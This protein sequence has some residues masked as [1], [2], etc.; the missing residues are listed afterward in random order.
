MVMSFNPRAREGR[1]LH[2]QVL[3]VALA[4]VSTHAP[5]RGATRLVSRSRRLQSRAVSTHAPARGATRSISSG[6]CSTMCF[7]PRAREGRDNTRRAIVTAVAAFQPTRPRGARQGFGGAH[8]CTLPVS[9]HAP[10]RGATREHQ[11][12][13]PIGLCFNPRAREGRDPPPLASNPSEGRRFN[14][15]AREG[16]DATARP[17]KGFSGAVSTHAPAR[18]ATSSEH[19]MLLQLA[20]KF[21]PTRPRGARPAEALQQLIKAGLFQP[22]RP[23]GARPESRED[24]I[25]LAAVSTHAPA[26][27]A[28]SPRRC[29]PSTATVVST[30]APARGAT[31]FAAPMHAP[32]YQFQP[33]RPRGARRCGYMAYGGKSQFQ[34]TR[35]RGARRVPG[36]RCARAG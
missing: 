6:G 25:T 32:R 20:A 1:D 10:A 21:Q 35:P 3:V 14:P 30:H 4:I 18:G 9:T 24:Q 7:N 16:R 22:T 28:T 27:G 12:Q 36:P 19:Y 29:L 2:I 31:F 15:R 26:R 34:P 33:T 8:A 5:A 17:V 23:R 11:S 13:T